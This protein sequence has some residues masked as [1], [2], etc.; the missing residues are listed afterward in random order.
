M[1]AEFLKPMKLKNASPNTADGIVNIVITIIG[2]ITFELNVSQ[3]I[4][5][6]LHLMYE[7]LIH[8]LG[9]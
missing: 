1:A 6:L 2:P 4:V 7:M 9:F 5:Y 8:I 3:L